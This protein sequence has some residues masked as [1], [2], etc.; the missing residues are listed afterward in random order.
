MSTS[1][2][3]KKTGNRLRRRVDKFKHGKVSTRNKTGG[4]RSKEKNDSLKKTFTLADQILTKLYTSGGEGEIKDLTANLITTK[5]ERKEIESIL[6][7]LLHHKFISKINRKTFKINKSKFFEGQLEVNPR[8][9]GFITPIESDEYPD[10]KTDIFVAGRELGTA[11]Q[12]DLVLAHIIDSRRGKPAGRIIGI[13][14]RS[15]KEL[16]G[17]YSK[18]NNGGMVIPDDDRFPFTIKIDEKS[19]LEANDGDAVIVELQDRAN[20]NIQPKGRIVKVLGNPNLSNVQMMMVIGK[21]DIPHVF[22]PESLSE[23][24]GFEEKIE[25]TENREDLR[26][27]L[28]VTIDGET[29]RDFDDAVGVI[30]TKKGFRLYVSIADVSHYVKPGTNIDKDAWERGT[31]IYF[32][33]GVIPMLPERLSN[34]L[35]SLKPDVDRYAFTAVLD[36]DRSGTR[37]KIRFMKSVI[38]SRYRLTYTLVRQI[39]VDKDPAIRR[40]NKPLLTPLKWMSELGVALEKKRISRGSM[41]FDI[42]EPF[43]EF[44]DN[45]TITAIKLR[46]RNLS[47]KIIEEFMLAANEAVAE[48]FAK[49]HFPCLYRIHESPDPLKVAQFAEFMQSLGYEGPRNREN[50]SSKWF[51]SLINQTKNTSREYLISN[52]ILRVMQQARYSPENVGHFGLAAQFYTHFTSPIRRYPDLMVHRGLKQLLLQEKNKQTSDRNL[53]EAGEFLSKRERVAVDAERDM[54]ERLKVRFMENKI[55]ETFDG[56]ISGMSPFGL[57]IELTETMISGGIAIENLPRDN[58]EFAE[59][60]HCLIGKKGGKKFQIGNMVKV[61]LISV[62]KRSRKINFILDETEHLMEGEKKSIAAG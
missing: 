56:I 37:Q 27:I 59:K 43:V 42:P 14:K 35:C 57:F 4:R 10:Q 7:E 28:H 58:Y 38:R 22:R 15:V 24:D 44:G 54:L 31:S 25:L 11:L 49:R 21:F 53:R 52:L 6:D 36:F 45:D 3:N 26:D 13:I 50:I 29:A 18:G 8:G 9:F 41:G 39:L 32:P 5:G 12:G 2:T 20:E 46:E 62:D 19:S 30:K 34:N 23:A 55:G 17:I 40:N 60:Q 1:R 16:A 51:N 61:Q 47:H 33:T 48:T